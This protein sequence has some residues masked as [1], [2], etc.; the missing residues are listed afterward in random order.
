MPTSVPGAARRE[1]DEQFDD[2]QREEH[3]GKRRQS[4]IGR[5]EAGPDR[6]GDDRAE[7]RAQRDEQKLVPRQAHHVDQRRRKFWRCGPPGAGPAVFWRK[8]IRPRSR[9]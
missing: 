1:T 2:A 7:D 3:D 6:P 9:S 8:L 4:A 5:D